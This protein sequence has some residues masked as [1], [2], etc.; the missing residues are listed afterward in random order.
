M[1]FILLSTV[2]LM[3]FSL[4]N[5]DSDGSEC[6][7]PTTG[8]DYVG[9]DDSKTIFNDVPVSIGNDSGIYITCSSADS[10]LQYNDKSI[11][12]LFLYCNTSVLHDQWGNVLE[13]G[14]D[15][16]SCVKSL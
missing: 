16:Y 11:E 4:I 5:C 15:A 2:C 12:Y 10:L 1:S 9:Y 7:V 3:S 6:V 8:T 13:S 14:K